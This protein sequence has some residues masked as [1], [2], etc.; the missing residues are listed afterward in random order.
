MSTHTV[1]I[2]LGTSTIKVAYKEKRFKIPSIIGEPNPSP[3]Q[4]ITAIDTSWE[5]NLVIKI[6]DEE[7]YVGELARLQSIIKIPLARE[8]KMK[9]AKS[10]LLAILSA[11]GLVLPEEKTAAIIATGV[12]VA[13]SENE[14]RELSK[15]AVGHHKFRIKNEATGSEKEFN[16]KILAAPVLPE[17]YGTYYYTLKKMGIKKA[18]DA[19]II[20]I[21]YGTTD[22]LSIHKGV[23]VKPASGSCTEA[24]DTIVEKLVAYI[25]SKT[26]ELL[27]PEAIAIALEKGLKI[28][29]KGVTYDL[30]PQVAALANYVAKSIIDTLDRL[31][32]NLPADA[33]IK[34]YIICGGGAYILGPY[35]KKALTET[36]GVKSEQIIVPDEPILS[37]ALGFE[38]VAQYYM[39]KITRKTREGSQ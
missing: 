25:E 29:V 10:A 16:V 1:G 2:D 12:P 30:K 9:D 3:F 15:L 21:G 37:N 8:G 17:P 22:I 38:L 19:V 28:A 24:V 18:F 31:L 7:W 32:R 27:K 6:G 5:N 20:D 33:M 11:L 23:M 13:T 14:M 39:S 35:I 36:Y 4:A 26:G 34:Y